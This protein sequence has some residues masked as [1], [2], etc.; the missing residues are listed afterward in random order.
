MNAIFTS[1]LFLDRSGFSVITQIHNW[2]H[3]PIPYYDSIKITSDVCPRGDLGQICC[4][5]LSGII[6]SNINVKPDV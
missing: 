2:G 1:N 6:T 5:S 3:D 4:V